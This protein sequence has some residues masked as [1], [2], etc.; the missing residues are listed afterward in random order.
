[1]IA[2]SRVNNFLQ[3]SL[4]PEARQSCD[5]QASASDPD[6]F[7]WCRLTWSS[8]TWAW[9]MSSGSCKAQGSI[10]KSCAKLRKISSPARLDV[11]GALKC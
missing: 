4:Q 3:V 5:L 7:M 9:A 10:Q 2:E 11:A 6:F 1:M 8:G